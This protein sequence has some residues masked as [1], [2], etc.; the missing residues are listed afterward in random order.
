MTSRFFCKKLHSHFHATQISTF[1]KS[2]ILENKSQFGFEYSFGSP[3]GLCCRD[4][5]LHNALPAA[6][7]ASTSLLM[8]CSSADRPSRERA[9]LLLAGAQVL[10]VP[11]DADGRSHPTPTGS[12]FGKKRFP[13]PAVLCLRLLGSCG[14]VCFVAKERL[15][16]QKSPV[17]PIC[18]SSGSA[19][20]RR[21]CK[22]QRC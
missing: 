12:H 15:R 9:S 18:V 7:Q 21:D 13:F 19:L 22:A 20:P 11:D 5:R 17:L 8:H 2:R 1:R 10:T 6:D 16:L 3:R 14:G 4:V